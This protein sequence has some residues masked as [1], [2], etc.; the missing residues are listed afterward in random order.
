MLCLAAYYTKCT[1]TPRIAEPRMLSHQHAFGP[2][3]EH[4]FLK[5]NN[6]KRI[7]PLVAPQVFAYL[8]RKDFE[9]L[10]LSRKSF[11]LRVIYRINKG[12]FTFPMRFF[13]A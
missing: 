5:N 6:I 1:S 11:N 7:D 13:F 10:Q 3:I 4:E 12:I 2:F 8:L 9:R